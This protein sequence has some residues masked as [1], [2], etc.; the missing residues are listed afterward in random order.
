MKRLIPLVFLAG[1]VALVVALSSGGGSKNQ[2]ANAQG[3][4]SY[5]GKSKTPPSTSVQRHLAGRWST[6][7][8]ER[9]TSSRPTSRM[10]A[11]ART[12]VSASGLP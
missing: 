6:P 3:S 2:S 9:S 8:G 7:K 11:T 5:G 10:R 1:I 4:G 12:P